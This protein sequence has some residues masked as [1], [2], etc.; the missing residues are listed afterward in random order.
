M[1]E[2]IQLDAIQEENA[3]ELVKRLLNTIEELSAGLREARAEIQRLRDEVNRMKGEQGKPKIKGNKAQGN[4]RVDHSSET[5]RRPKKRKRHKKS[6]KSEVAIHREEVVKVDRA[7]LPADAQYKGYERVIVQDLRLQAEN[8]L[9][10]K[11]KYYSASQ[12][13]TYLADLPPGYAGQFG[14][15]IRSL[16]LTLSFGVGTSEPQIHEFLPRTSGRCRASGGADLERGSE[17]AVDPKA[18]KV[19]CRERSGV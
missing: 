7:Q 11:E 2:D 17:P 1:F 18:G 10:Y 3:R 4:S 14:P 13:K 5:E 15:G 19:S 6:K 12:H 16:I 9:F 8:V